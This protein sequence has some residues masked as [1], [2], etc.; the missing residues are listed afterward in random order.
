MINHITLEMANLCQISI[1][2]KAVID[3]AAEIKIRIKML[4]K[5]LK[6]YEPTIIALAVQQGGKIE[7]ELGEIT[8]CQR[9][10]Y[11]FSEEVEKLEEQKKKLEERIKA[12]QLVEV[13][14]GAA[15]TEKPYLRYN[16]RVI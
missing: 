3:K 16:V 1:S 9:K 13:T 11:Q 14:G 10:E 6:D 4:E 5:E 8:L 7:S 15:Y 12:K 2:P